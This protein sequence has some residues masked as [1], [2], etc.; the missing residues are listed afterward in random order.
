MPTECSTDPFWGTNGQQS[1]A[2]PGSTLNC[3]YDNKN[4]TFS[5]FSS[6]AV[7]DGTRPLPLRAQ[8]TKELGRTVSIE[9]TDA[10]WVLDK[11]SDD[12]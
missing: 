8:E 3:S 1:P 7:F 9:G 6:I 2:E 4:S 5:K 12:L 10:A 11:P